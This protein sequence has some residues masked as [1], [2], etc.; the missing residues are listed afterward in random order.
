VELN[1][2]NWS[3]GVKATVTVVDDDIDDGSQPCVIRTGPAVSEDRLYDGLDPAD[4]DVTVLDE[5]E[6]GMVVVPEALTLSEPDEEGVFTVLLTSQPTDV[7]SVTLVS[8]DTGEC[9]VTP[10]WVELNETNWSEGVRAT[11]T[12]VDDDIVDGS[13]RCVVQTGPAVSDDPLYGSLDPKDVTVTVL[14]EGVT[15][16]YMPLVLRRWPPVPD[17]PALAPI[18]NADGNGTYSISWSSVP[19]AELYILEESSNVTFSD[20]RVLSD[21]SRTSYLV[22]GGGAGRRYYRVKARNQWGD[23]DW[24]NIRSADVLW[25]AEPNDERQ[26]QA[27]GPLISGLTYYGTFPSGAD[28]QDYY[29]FDL[30]TPHS[31]ELW[32]TDIPA[33][34]NYDL[35]LRDAVGNDIG[36]SGEPGNASE[37][38][39]TSSLPAGQYYIQVYHRSLGGSSQPYRLYLI[40][41]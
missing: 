1:E 23:S 30:I 34:H 35:V 25:E 41:E 12:V 16:I 6:R 40:Y 7:V 32:L 37:H 21:D 8:T 20:V 38:I 5:D 27:N 36:Y 11:V 26:T 31:V 2:T 19:V 10:G 9:Q 39:L 28:I 3:E 13:Q 18:D 15:H 24:S 14:D 4:V 22:T 17:P 29:Y 33:G